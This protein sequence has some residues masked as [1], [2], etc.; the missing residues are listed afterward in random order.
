MK[1]RSK[2]LLCARRPVVD[3]AEG[4]TASIYRIAMDMTDESVSSLEDR[5]GWYKLPDILALS[6]H[7]QWVLIIDIDARKN[8]PL[9]LLIDA[10]KNSI[11][12]NWVG[13]ICVR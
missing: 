12:E 3:P 2:V 5:L 9:D 4:S 1:K 7:V 6:P 10:W 8:G 13:Y 11:M